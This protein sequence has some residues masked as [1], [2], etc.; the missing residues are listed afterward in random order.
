MF[1]PYTKAK[2]LKSWDI[3]SMWMLPSRSL[4]NWPQY[5]YPKT[6]ASFVVLVDSWN[7]FPNAREG[8]GVEGGSIGEFVEL[9]E[10]AFEISLGSFAF[11]LEQVSA[12]PRQAS[13]L[14][15]SL[16]K[17]HLEYISIDIK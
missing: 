3:T 10:I 8:K 17:S 11:L 16:V 15:V 7:G 2:C 14:F 4:A 9:L 1:G 13:H 5:A 12:L 6:C